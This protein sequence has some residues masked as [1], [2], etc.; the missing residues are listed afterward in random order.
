LPDW[1]CWVA[2]DASGTWWGYEAEPNEG[3]DFWYEN[4]VGRCIKLMQAS[5]NPD[6]RSSLKRL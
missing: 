2:Q 3:Y 1:V 6:W 5:P 4:E